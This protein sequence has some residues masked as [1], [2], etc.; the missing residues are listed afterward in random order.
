MAMFIY[1]TSY[2]PTWLELKQ[3]SILWRSLP[4]TV[5]KVS[6]VE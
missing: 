3:F 6:K 5:I 2:G 1:R 4:K